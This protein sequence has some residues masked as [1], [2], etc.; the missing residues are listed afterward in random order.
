MDF[1]VKR[2]DGTPP[3]RR[4]TEPGSMRGGRRHDPARRNPRRR[5]EP[6]SLEGGPGRLTSG[7]ER[8]DRRP[9]LE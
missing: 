9:A 2:T 8:S 1:K 7:N 3:I 4:H 5:P 6:R